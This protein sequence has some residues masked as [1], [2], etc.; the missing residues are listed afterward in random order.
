M[1]W[2]VPSRP[3]ISNFSGF[4]GEMEI[5]DDFDL[6]LLTAEGILADAPLVFLILRR[7]NVRFGF[8]RSI[9]IP[10][11]ARID[12]CPSD[13]VSVMARNM[14]NDF[15]G[16]ATLHNSARHLMYHRNITIR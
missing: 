11:S 1:V 5:E 9:S 13:A 12:N 3:F 2:E 16:T 8:V 10:T 14:S 6:L 7:R 15:F 4:V